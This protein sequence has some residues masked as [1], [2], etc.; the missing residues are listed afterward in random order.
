MS[1]LNNTK[2]VINWS[3]HEQYYRRRREKEEKQVVYVIDH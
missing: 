2:I 1:F 3:I